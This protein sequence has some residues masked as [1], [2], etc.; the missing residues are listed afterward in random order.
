MPA[1]RRQKARQVDPRRLRIGLI[2][3]MRA[4]M[5]ARTKVEMEISRLGWYSKSG[6]PVVSKAITQL[7]TLNYI[8]ERVYLRLNTLFVASYLDW[9]SLALLANTLKHAV[10]SLNN[11]PPEVTSQLMALEGLLYDLWAGVEAP[12]GEEAERQ[13]TQVNDEA[14]RIIQ[15]A[16][17][18]ARRSVTGSGGMATPLGG[19]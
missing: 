5:T 3:A 6:D 11:L 17:E 18:A 12:P 16:Q 15:E 9:R 8:L 4:V 1:L 10:S 2:E 13:L 19:A 14:R 7:Y